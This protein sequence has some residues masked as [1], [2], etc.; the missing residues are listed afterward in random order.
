MVHSRPSSIMKTLCSLTAALVLSLNAVASQ[1]ATQVDP[2]LPPVGELVET[3]PLAASA[4]DK[5]LILP[6]LTVLVVIA[7]SPFVRRAFSV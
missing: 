7:A 5:T 1:P 4:T 6:F 2:A 3:R